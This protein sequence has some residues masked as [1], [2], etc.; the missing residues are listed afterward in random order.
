M[1]DGTGCEASRFTGS[2]SVYRKGDWVVGVKK[3]GRDEGGW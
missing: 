3:G 2:W 1:E